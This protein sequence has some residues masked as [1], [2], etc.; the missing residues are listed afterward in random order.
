MLESSSFNV[1]PLCFEFIVHDDWEPLD[2]E[3]YKKLVLYISLKDID[4][5]K[6]V[7]STIK[8]IQ[9]ETLSI[10]FVD[11]E[12]IPSYTKKMDECMWKVFENVDLGKTKNLFQY[13]SSYFIDYLDKINTGE[14]KLYDWQ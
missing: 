5:I 1:G 10:I 7:S 12:D 13:I 14:I 6:I 3:T 4:G 11:M 2:I 8:N 9:T